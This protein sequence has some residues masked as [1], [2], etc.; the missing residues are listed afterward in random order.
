MDLL[1][2]IYYFF[3][4]LFTGKVESTDGY[5]GNMTTPS[6]ILTLVIIV[7]V[8]IFSLVGV[9]LLVTKTPIGDF[10]QTNW[11][12]MLTSLVIFCLGFISG[13]VYERKR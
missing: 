1:K 12:S 9:V 4:R 6:K 11:V 5:V 2:R 3:R 10:I 8:G 13:V 7:A